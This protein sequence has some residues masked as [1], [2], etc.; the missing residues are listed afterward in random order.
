MI[1]LQQKVNEIKSEFSRQSWPHLYYFVHGDAK[2]HINT[3]I[4]Y[5]DVLE[6][7]LVDVVK[8]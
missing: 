1:E 4:N 6:K 3:L 2:S 7:I 8:K 5:I